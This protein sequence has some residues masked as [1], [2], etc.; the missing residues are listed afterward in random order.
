MSLRQQNLGSIV[1]PGFNPLGAQ[2]TTETYYLYDW[3]SNTAGASG[4]GNTTAYSSPKQVGST[5]DWATLSAGGWYVQLAVK[6]DGTL[7]AWGN[8]QRGQLGL[9]NK[10]SYSS[11]KQVGA[12][13]N[14]LKVAAAK[15]HVWG[16]KTNGTLWAWGESSGT[17]GAQ[18]LNGNT[19]YSSPVQIGALTN[20]LDISVC[21]T[22]SMALK[23]NGTI[24]ACGEGANGFLG[25]SSTTN[26]SS[27]AQIGALTTW[28]RIQANA[29]GTGVAYAIKTDGTLWA[30]GVGSVGSLGL[31]NLTS[32]SSP[33]QIGALT[34]WLKISANGYAAAAIK[35]NGT[36]WTWG[37]NSTGQLGDSSLVTK[38]SPVQIG[39]NTNWSVVG[40]GSNANV[41]AVKTDGTLWSWGRGDSGTNGLGN[42]TAYSS[43]K[44]VGSDTTWRTVA[45]GRLDAY[46]LKV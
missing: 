23:T 44:Q 19:A 1:K 31:N 39:A 24:W 30:W 14:W 8:G 5:T 21:N 7:W 35:T 4:I 45:S 43:P 18:G 34:N 38:S 32:Y 9:G 25:N 40:S 20:W 13:T 15:Y 27:P 6:T 37:S 3:G 36:L 10:T 26:I 16:L 29:G 12:L 33:K 46:A 17:Y 42:N 11:P 28:A 2:T 41:L 22:N